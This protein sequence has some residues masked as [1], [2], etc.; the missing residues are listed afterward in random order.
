MTPH[1][2]QSRLL[3][4]F[5]RHG[6]KDL[7]WQNPTTP[8]RVWISEVMLQQTQ[9]ATVI[10]YFNAFVARF[11]D[12]DTLA[13]APIDDVLQHWA[14]LGYYARARN[15]H[16][17][18]RIIAA[19]G[20]FPD[21][22]DELVDLPGI[23]RSTA[24]AILSIA[25]KKSHPI[26]DGNVK[27]VLARFA[28][29]EGWP[30]STQTSK[31]LWDLSATYTPEQRPADYTQ[32]IM[33]LGA[34]VCTRSKPNCTICPVASACVAHIEGK[35]HRLPSTK[36]TRKQPIK[37]VYFL[38]AQDT[39]H[40][41]LLQQRPASGIWGGLWS[42]PEF[43][44]IES[45]KAW[46]TLRNLDT[47]AELTLE[48]QR[49]TFSHYHLDYTPLYVLVDNPTNFVMEDNRELW[50]KPEQFLSLALAAPIKRLLQTLY[51]DTL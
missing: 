23:G 7:P 44:S 24:G 18:A 29:I 1:D 31:K 43:E 25:F 28:G 30:G 35:T 20:T 11:P 41:I 50:Y 36:P 49:H 22:F 5:D 38:C 19:R 40:R 2:F 4:W 37:Q 46:C 14:G 17:S 45:A 34:T 9:V 26:L 27:R 15:L 33:D 6:R 13:S 10:P 12:I 16:D 39:E 48:R 51:E 3:A 8:Y 32:A 47:L 42:F 21:N